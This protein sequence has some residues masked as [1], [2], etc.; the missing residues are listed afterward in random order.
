M[1]VGSNSCVDSV[2]KA[3]LPHLQPIPNALMVVVVVRHL[4]VWI[5]RSHTMSLWV[6][7]Y[8]VLCDTG[9]WERERESKRG[10]GN[11]KKRYNS[12]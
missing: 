7:R 6:M 12:A 10:L 5:R 3:H 2:A 8:W 1:A 9:G 11:I 4:I